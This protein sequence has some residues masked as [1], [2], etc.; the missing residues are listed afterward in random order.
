MKRITLGT[1]MA[2]GLLVPLTFVP[3][4]DRNLP[5]TG[6][7]SEGPVPSSPLELSDL[8]PQQADTVW[9]Q[10]IADGESIAAS[11]DSVSVQQGQAVGWT[12]ELGNWRVF[13]PEPPPFAGGGQGQGRGADRGQKRG[14]AIREDA[15]PRSYKYDIQVIIPG[16]GAIRVDP[17]IVVEPRRR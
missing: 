13:F 3:A 5:G 15:T 10:I 7:A 2:L 12:S 16:R 8:A 17:E 1:L 14:W 4:Q 6:P 9:I 11:P